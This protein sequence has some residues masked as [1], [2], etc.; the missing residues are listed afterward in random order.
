MRAS[1]YPVTALWTLPKRMLKSSPTECLG[2]IVNSFCCQ[3]QA[4]LKGSLARFQ[5]EKEV[6]SVIDVAI[7]AGKLAQEFE[8]SLRLTEVCECISRCILH[9]FHHI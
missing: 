6:A 8:K 1:M 4:N 2:T 3:W 9:S 5:T 7:R